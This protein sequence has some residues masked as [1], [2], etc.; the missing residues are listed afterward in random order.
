MK[1]KADLLRRHGSHIR[2]PLVS[3]IIPAQNEAKSIGRV[4]KEAKKVSKRTEVIVVCNGTSDATAQIARRAGAKVLLYRQALGHDVGRAVGAR[5]AK[6]L[7]LLFLDADFSVPSPVL[8]KYCKAVRNGCDVALNAYS[9]YTTR[10]FIHSTSEAK[11]LL[12]RL[13]G[14]SDLA[15]SS[16]T[17]VPHAMT[18]RAA[19]LI[20]YPELSVPPKAQV[21]AIMAGLQVEKAVH[22][23]VAKLNRV[24]TRNK[25]GNYVEQLILADHAEAIEYWLGKSRSEGWQNIEK[26]SD[27]H[28][29]QLLEKVPGNAIKPELSLVFLYQDA[30]H[31]ERIE[32]EIQKAQAVYEDIAAAEIWFALSD[33]RQPY[34]ARAAAAEA[35]EGQLIL[36]VDGSL[37]FQYQ[38]LIPLLAACRCGADI[39]LSS[40]RPSGSMAKLGTVPMAVRYLNRMMQRRQLGFASLLHVPHAMTANAVKRISPVY[41][42]IPPL[43]H[44]F[45]V[46]QGMKIE[47]A[48][49][50]PAGYPRFSAWEDQAAIQAHL[51]ALDWLQHKYGARLFFQDTSRRRD[52]VSS[53]E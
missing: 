50:T 21:K 44:S 12:N 41:L 33:L 42:G 45:A 49:Q 38:T 5:L 23:N 51:D 37:P 35:A 2:R 25:M 48:R 26:I 36:F 20:G 29:H 39:A 14:R 9:G 3:V 53:S 18:R 24:R 13:L 43:A 22:F 27:F 8:K 7:V 46:L 40:V 30:L 28:S 10:T 6:G 17:A 4:V 19:E 52:A 15:G 32:S 31:R 1:E 16:L 34:A 11:R 47:V